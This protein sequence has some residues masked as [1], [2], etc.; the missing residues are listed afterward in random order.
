VNAKLVIPLIWTTS[1]ALVV[2]L[3]TAWDQMPSRVAVHFGTDMQPN[4]WGSKNALAAIAVLAV[5][6]QA[7]L[8][9]FVLLRIGSAP[10]AI[11]LVMVMVNIALVSAFWQTIRYNATG[12]PFQPL[13]MFL[14]LIAVF[15]FATVFMVKLM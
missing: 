8:A 12:A 10:I 11:T 6:G 13:W 1:A 7:A 2:K 15:V 5:V 9:T 4:R 14:A 3:V